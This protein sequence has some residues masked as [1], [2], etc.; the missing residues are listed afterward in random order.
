MV[1]LLGRL[2]LLQR[3][4]HARGMKLA[5]VAGVA[6]VA[7][8]IGH[9]PAHI[10]YAG[11]QDECDDEILRIHFFDCANLHSKD[12]NLSCESLLFSDI[13]F[14]FVANNKSKGFE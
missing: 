14:I 11:Q 3:L 9:A 10:P 8:N 4:L 7:D 12:S 13:L 1:A 2:P 5:A 6:C